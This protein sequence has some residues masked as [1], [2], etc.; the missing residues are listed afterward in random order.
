M[1]RRPMFLAL[2]AAATV[3]IVVP[4]TVFGFPAGRSDPESFAHVY[5]FPTNG[6]QTHLHIDADPTNGTR[7]CDPIDTTR[8]V[9]VGDTYDVGLCLESYA[10]E[11]VKAFKLRVYYDDINEAATIDC[12]DGDTDADPHCLDANP[13]ANDGDDDVTG[14]TLGSNWDCSGFGYLPPLGE[15]PAT[16]CEDEYGRPIYP[17]LDAVIACNYSPLNPDL[18]LAANPGLLG[19]VEFTATGVG[20]E[21]LTW[22]DDTEVGGSDVGLPNGG[23]ALCGTDVPA[24][25]VACFSATINKVVFDCVWE[26]SFGRGTYLGL[27]GNDWE[28]GS[29]EGTFSGTG[30]VMRIGDRAFVFG[31][32]DGFY[33]GGFGTCPS[34]PG[35]AFGLSTLPPLFLRVQDVTGE[36]D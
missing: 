6:N 23:F 19:T 26:D 29:P 18:D 22:G 24:D 10:P 17:C 21:S 15:D 34:G 35:T 8:T 11:E 12:L 13:N 3:A 4:I 32:G 36:P 7:P 1:A 30:H 14:L 28:F 16:P 31:R 33:L 27:L 2:V 20:T 9:Q 25:Q 5:T